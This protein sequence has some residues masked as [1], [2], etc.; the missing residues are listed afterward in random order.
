MAI[1][2]LPF[3]ILGFRWCHSEEP[4]ATGNL[5]WIEI[6][7]GVYPEQNEILRGV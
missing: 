5:S 1:L 6:S 4:E 2:D 7:H 3:S